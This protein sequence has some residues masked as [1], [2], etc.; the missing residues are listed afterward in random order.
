M[1]RGVR[2]GIGLAWVL[3]VAAG[4]RGVDLLM[5]FGRRQEKELAQKRDRLTRLEGWLEVEGKVVARWKETLGR[6]APA[7]GKEVGWV[8][9]QGLQEAAQ[10]QGLAITDLRPIQV[11]GQGKREA[12]FRV[13]AKLEGDLAQVDRLL[14]E[15]PQ[16]L[17]GVRLENFQLVPLGGG[18][19]Q[20]VVRVEWT[21]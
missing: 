16:A 10:G 14:Q 9:L 7:E 11:K 3:V 19:A 4:T 20:S 15:L 5:D 18:K 17:P 21:G 12:F 6:F 13:D 2:L 8:I 1:T